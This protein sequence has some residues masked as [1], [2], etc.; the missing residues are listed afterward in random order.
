M[1]KY[2]TGD[3]LLTQANAIAHGV[4]PNDSFAQ[5][6]ALSL[7]ESWPAMYKDFR[8]YS[9]THHP[10]EG[11]LWSWKGADGPVMISLFTQEHA[12]SHNEHPGKASESYVNHALKHLAKEIQKLEIKS[13]ALPKLATG[14]GG[15]SWETVKP[16]IEKHLGDT[17]AQVIVYENFQKGQKAQ[18]GL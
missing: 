5:G 11:D 4:A 15:L 12:S 14:V 3:I 2:V 18:E 10:K 6:L 7:R 17:G 16:L 8:H 1:V 9:H 13:I